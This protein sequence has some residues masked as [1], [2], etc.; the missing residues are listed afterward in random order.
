MLHASQACPWNEPGV[1]WQVLNTLGRED[2]ALL[3]RARALPHMMPW[4][5]SFFRNSRRAAYEENL[6]KNARLADYSLAVM[7][8]HFR[9][10]PMSVDRADRGTLKIYRSSAELEVAR[11]VADPLRRIIEFSM[12]WREIRGNLRTLAACCASTPPERSP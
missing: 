3:I 9:A 7:N 4:A 11:E 8:E 2:S 12:L 6:E 10:L 5:W 1:L